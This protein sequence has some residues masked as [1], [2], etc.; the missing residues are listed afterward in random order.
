MN[1]DVLSF[2]LLHGLLLVDMV[3]PV[4]VELRE[5]CA[6]IINKQLR[7]FFVRLN[8]K[9]KELAMVVIDYVA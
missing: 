3:L 8:Y 7:Q 1:L 6:Y 4:L 5:A 9:A 2:D